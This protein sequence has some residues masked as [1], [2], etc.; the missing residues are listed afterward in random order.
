MLHYLVIPKE[1]KMVDRPIVV[2]I[3][4]N[5]EDIFNNEL[6]VN[7]YEENELYHNG[8]PFFRTLCT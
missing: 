1:R 5:T 8:T 2:Y 6:S 3:P 4:Y 7:P